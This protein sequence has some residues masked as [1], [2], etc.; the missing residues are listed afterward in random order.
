MKAL[1]TASF[2]EAGVVA[3]TTA[4]AC[5][6]VDSP[7]VDPGRRFWTSCHPDPDHWVLEA[8]SQWAGYVLQWVK[9]LVLRLCEKPT[10]EAKMYAWIEQR[11]SEVPPLVLMAPLPS[12]VR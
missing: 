11:A 8:N 5:L 7:H 6:L 2:D 12:W 3:G 4:P 9:D 10:T 1:I